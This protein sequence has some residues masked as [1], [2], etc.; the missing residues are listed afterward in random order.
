MVTPVE[1]A[2]L[3]SSI[4]TTKY[5]CRGK[6]Y[7]AVSVAGDDGYSSRPLAIFVGEHLPAKP[8]LSAGVQIAIDHV[9]HIDGLAQQFNGVHRAAHRD[10]VA[11]VQ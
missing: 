2:V 11:A 7:S 9:Q 4:G 1:L 6:R 3:G 8:C 5:G 10:L